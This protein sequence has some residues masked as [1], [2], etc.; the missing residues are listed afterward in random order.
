M[1]TPSLNLLPAETLISIAGHLNGVPGPDL[2]SFS[3]TNRAFHAAAACFLFR[4]IHILVKHPR[5][6]QRDVDVWLAILERTNSAR[7]V[8]RLRMTFVDKTLPH[9]D[10]YSP[11]RHIMLPV[12]SKNA[13]CGKHKSPESRRLRDAFVDPESWTPMIRLLEAL[14]GLTNL[15]IEHES[16]FSPLLL[17][18]LRT[19]HPS[20]RLELKSFDLHCVEG[21]AIDAHD[22]ALLLSP[23]L[24]GISIKEYFQ[25]STGHANESVVLRLI[26]GLSPSLKTVELEP[27]FGGRHKR[28]YDADFE[29]ELQNLI[30]QIVNDSPVSG[31]NLSKIS[32]SPELGS[33]RSLTLQK[34]NPDRL[35]AWFEA[36][37]FTAL[38]HLR[39]NAGSRDLL[40]L[41][42][43]A[44]FHHLEN[45]ELNY[46]EYRI[47]PPGNQEDVGIPG[48]VAVEFLAILPALTALSLEGQITSPAVQFALSKFGG[49]LRKLSIRPSYGF[50]SMQKYPK[51]TSQDLNLLSKAC[52]LV[53]DL[54]ITIAVPTFQTSSPE[55]VEACESLGRMRSLRSLHLT[56]RHSTIEVTSGP[57]G[58][59]RARAYQRKC[60]TT[61]GADIM[62]VTPAE[63][64]KSVWETIC[65][66]GC[67]LE[68][69]QLDTIHHYSGTRKS[70]RVHQIRR[71]GAMGE[72]V[73][74]DTLIRENGKLHW[75][76]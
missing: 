21:A 41:T 32:K 1:S 12:A 22:V 46:G 54:T 40:W 63:I 73:V 39:L 70:D 23:Q 13:F 27:V 10:L 49:S 43:H 17:E 50:F 7:H 3:L 9:S 25:I 8:R 69:L 33:L 29:S 61:I 48:D 35:K 68:L 60:E 26:Q 34:N 52:S 28:R 56:L 20:C 71:V 59:R 5:R 14:P 53:A 38:R 37:D 62:G 24:Q 45:L 2:S 44:R 51:I 30:L 66:R 31:K 65:G 76:E 64:A 36:T 11:D 58:C 75:R 19:H 55:M 16:S 47:G 18:T 67:R 72:G 6:L 74:E 57:G 15:V 4:D 42:T